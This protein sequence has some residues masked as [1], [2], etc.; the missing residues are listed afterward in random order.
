LGLGVKLIDYFDEL[1]KMPSLFKDESMLDINFIPEKLPH[2]EKELYLLSR[3]FLTLITNPNST[4]R[5]ILITGKT[6]VGKTVTVKSFA[7]MLINASIKRHLF[8]KYVHI[9]CR[10]ER[11]SYKALIKIVRTINDKFPKRGYSPQDLL[12]II[13]DHLNK[14]DYHLLIVLDEL[15][16]LINNGED[17][18]YSLTRLNDDSINI[19]QRISIIGIVRDISCLSNLDAS[20]LSTLQRNIIEFKVYSRE[21]IFDILKY[22]AGICLNEKVISDEILGMITDLVYNKGDIRF[23]LNLIWRSVKIA[24]NKGLKH[25]SAECVRLGNQDLVPFSTQD[26]LKCISI[27]KLVFLLSIIRTLKL[28]EDKAISM[29]EILNLYKIICENLE[30]TSRSQ[31]QLWN[32]LQEFKRDNLITLNVQSEA[33]KGR[34]SLIQIPEISLIKF[35]KIVLE[36]LESKGLNI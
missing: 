13:I 29:K 19:Q 5:K 18:I 21:E 28:S 2:R 34:K 27:Q 31:S 36:L 12:D 11:T 20:T 24:E 32:Y 16:Y 4:S 23:G 33:I 30:V 14:K 15:S 26:I 6:G 1:L 8:M 22:R 3:L 7:K 25:L 17:L 35:E 9:N 10:K